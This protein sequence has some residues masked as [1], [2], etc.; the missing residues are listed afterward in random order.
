MY[1]NQKS[2]YESHLDCFFQRPKQLKTRMIFIIVDLDS[3][4]LKKGKQQ[5]LH[6]YNT[7]LIIQIVT[8]RMLFSLILHVSQTLHPNFT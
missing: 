6:V 5:V 8:Q 7:S 1:L 4:Y 3:R 2:M